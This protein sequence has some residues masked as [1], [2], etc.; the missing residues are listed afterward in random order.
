VPD[1]AEAS[2][3]A[4]LV[5]GEEPHKKFDQIV[6][7]IRKQGFFVVAHEPTIEERRAHPRVVKVIDQ[8][9]YPASRTPMDL[10]VSKTLVR[11]LQQAKN[12]QTVVAPMLGGSVPMYIFEDLG[13]PWIGVPIVNYDNHQHSP[14][15]N[16]RL[17]NLWDGIETYAVLLADLDW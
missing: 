13:L 14:D 15:E 17:G 3:E 8:G 6:A 12:N 9:G 11:V 4:R 16:L 5:K 1:K 7:F 10:T 2:L